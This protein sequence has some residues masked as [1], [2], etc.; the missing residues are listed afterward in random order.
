MNLMKKIL[1]ITLA[2]AVMLLVGCSHQATTTTPQPPTPS[3]V[4]LASASKTIADGLNTAEATI[5]ALRDAGTITE[6]DA[7]AAQNFLAIIATTGKKMDAIA[8]PGI[9]SALTDAQKLAIAQLWEAAGLQAASAKLSQ[10]QQALVAATINAVN[11]VLA[12][13]GGKAL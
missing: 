1:S 2:M 7:R 9:G 12:S 13:V 11:A 3:S 8:T 4:T 10:S 5:K 6:S